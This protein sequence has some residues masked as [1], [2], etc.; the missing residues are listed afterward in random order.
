MRDD[1]CRR[2]GLDP[3]RPILLYVGSSGFIAAEEARFACR[4][5]AEMR[6]CGDE[7]LEQ[8][9]VLFRPHPLNARQWSAVDVSDV[10]NVAIFP[11][12][13]AYVTTEQAKADFF[14]SIY[15]SAA[16]VGI[17]TSAMIEAGIVGRVSHTILVPEFADTQEGTLHFDYLVRDGYVKVAPNFVEHFRQ[18]RQTLDVGPEG[19]E[20]VREFISSFVR[21]HGI[22]Q[23]CTPRVADAIEELGRLPR[24]PPMPTSWERKMGRIA[25]FFVAC[26][27]LTM[28][29]VYRAGV[30]L[31]RLARRTAAALLGRPYEDPRL[32]KPVGPIRPPL[33]RRRAQHRETVSEEV[34]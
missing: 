7:V 33:Q 19:Q 22:D 30:K 14:D 10:E 12:E 17:N 2:L 5:L 29:F 27:S 9:N 18:L 23:P 21:P 11:R 25:L 20:H 16:V 6:A 24:R 4:W 28:E 3:G 1:F 15:H 32:P 13:G 31:N 26:L 34:R 8:C